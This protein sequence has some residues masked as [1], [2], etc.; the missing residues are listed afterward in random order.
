MCN[1]YTCLELLQWQA[2]AVLFGA[3][4]KE[5]EILLEAA[6]GQRT[7]NEGQPG[8]GEQAAQTRGESEPAYRENKI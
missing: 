7:T 5:Y 6:A 2:A 1:K 3:G 8:D 4:A